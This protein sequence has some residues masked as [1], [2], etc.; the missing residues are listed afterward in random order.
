MRL[1]WYVKAAFKYLK[2][3]WRAIKSATCVSR[4]GT[5]GKYNQMMDN[6]HEANLMHYTLLRSV[7]A[8]EKM[9]QLF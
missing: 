9:N 7:L 3:N 4:G 6:Y 2:D 1:R 8:I 5:F